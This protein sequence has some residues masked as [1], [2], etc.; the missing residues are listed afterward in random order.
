MNNTI[1]KLGHIGK[2]EVC[3]TET[4]VVRN[5]CVKHRPPVIKTPGDLVQIFQV[6]LD[7]LVMIHDKEPDNIE[8]VCAV[9][10]VCRD[11]LDYWIS[12]K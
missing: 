4:W 7:A 1:E 10:D 12:L 5:R 6:S 8:K 2:C 11:A 3:E 9:A